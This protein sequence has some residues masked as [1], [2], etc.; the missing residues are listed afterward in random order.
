[1]NRDQSKGR[2]QAA[3]GKARETIGQVKGDANLEQKGKL[4]KY[5]GRAQAA[6]GNLKERIM[7]ARP[8]A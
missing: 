1:M 3:N 4:Q 7:N 6:Y 8:S 5:L 2:I